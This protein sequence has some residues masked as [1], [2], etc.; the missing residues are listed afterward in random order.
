MKKIIK[1]SPRINL[2]NKK[3]RKNQFYHFIKSPNVSIIIPYINKKKFLII[4]QKR[5]PINKVNYEFPS[6]WV[7]IN[8]MP[9]NSAL[10]ELLE[11]TGFKSLSK[12]KKLINV[13]PDPGRLSHNVYGYWTN[14]LIKIKK[15]EKGMKVKICTANQ[16]I[17]L[18]KKAKFNNSSHIALFF[19]FLYNF[20]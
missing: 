17:K 4:S 6:G 11:E 16:I 14:K 20:C 1:L 15:P 13:Y 3:F 2:V 19:Y 12:P 9:K 10:R 18:I 8:E 7:D 5:I